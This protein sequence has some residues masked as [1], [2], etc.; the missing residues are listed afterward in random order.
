MVSQELDVFLCRPGYVRLASG[1]YTLQDKEK[2]RHLTNN[3]LQKYSKHYKKEELIISPKMLERHV[4]E[5]TDP[6]YSFEQKT[7]P[8][9]VMFVRL[10][11]LV[12]LRKRALIFEKEEN[13][14]DGGKESKSLV[15]RVCECGKTFDR[16]KGGDSENNNGSEGGPR[17]TSKQ[18]PD[19]QE[20]DQIGPRN[21]GQMRRVFDQ[22]RQP[23]AAGAQGQEEE[24]PA[25][26][27]PE[28]GAFR[29]GIVGPNQERGNLH[30]EQIET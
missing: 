22:N 14:I 10:L 21:P 7:M 26:A 5:T 19:F 25:R 20:K 4:Q 3:S 9:I 23:K 12:L 1:S 11:G 13:L 29:G 8:E 28:E 15:K 18:E 2:F 24:K 6:L 17:E 30:E 27:V 16:V